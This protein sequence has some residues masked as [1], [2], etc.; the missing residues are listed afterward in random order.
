MVLHSVL[1]YRYDVSLITD[2]TFDKWARE[3]VKLQADYPDI[4]KKS[5]FY[6]EFITWDGTTGFD[7][8]DNQWGISKAL[9]MIRWQEHLDNKI[10]DEE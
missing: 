3:L 1:Y 8:A 4:T 10:N 7:L 5:V 6:N 9:Q 2:F